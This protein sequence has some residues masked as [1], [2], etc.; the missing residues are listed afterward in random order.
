MNAITLLLGSGAL[1]LTA[2]F[3]YSKFLGKVM[4]IDPS[5]PTPAITHADGVDYCAAPAPVLFGHHFASI[6]G[7]GPIVGPILAAEFGWAAVTL[8]VVLGC[9][10][11]G[12]VHDMF[13]QFLSIR[14]EGKSMAVVIESQL[15]RPAR[16]C[17]LAVCWFGLVMVCAE[18]TRQVAVTFTMRPAVASSSLLF[19]A[20]AVVFGLCV[21]RAKMP[22]LIASIIFVTIMFSFVWLGTVIPCDLTKMGYTIQQAQSIWTVVILAYCFLASTLPVWILLQPRDYLNS[23]LLYVMVALG[24]V[25]VLFYNPALELPA[26]VGFHTSGG[27]ALM[28]FMFITVA[29]GACSGFHSLVASGTTA[30]QI[31]NESHVRPVAYG[32][33]LL[34]GVLAL[35]ALIAVSYLVPNTFSSRLAEGQTPVM[36]FANGLAVFCSKLHIPLQ[37]AETFFSLAIAAFLMTTVDTSTRLTRFITQ[38]FVSTVR[39][40]KKSVTAPTGKEKESCFEIIWTTALV[41]GAMAA[42]LF[43]DKETTSK[44]WMTFASINQFLAALTF[45]TATLWC[46]NNK[47]KHITVVAVPLVFMLSMSTYAIITLS[48][49]AVTKSNWTLLTASSV[50]LLVGLAVVLMALPKLFKR[51]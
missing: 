25:A 4:G 32:G 30:K 9:I 7:A 29:C 21:Y 23:Y 33:M 11:I 43:G 46:I 19:I 5:R 38:E 24:I 34:E 2:Y 10:F 37:I 18:F 44:L 50:V 22:L 1:F 15:G 40:G 16:I 31:A 49:D 14:H 27:K 48:I 3:V 28:P 36:M 51:S 45:L 13:A 17:L 20:E 8:W 41:I 26:F 35:L 42:L 6:A 47:K 12:A 39:L